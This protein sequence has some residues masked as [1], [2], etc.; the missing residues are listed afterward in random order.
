LVNKVITAKIFAA[1]KTIS[2]ARQTPNRIS[3]VCPGRLEAADDEVVGMSTPVRVPE[4]VLLQLQ[5]PPISVN[6]SEP[7][8]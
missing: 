5:L 7:H 6:P 2:A 3:T 1:S 4:P 8:A